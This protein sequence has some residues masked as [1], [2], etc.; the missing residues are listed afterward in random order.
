MWKYLSLAKHIRK[1]WRFPSDK[2]I[3]ELVILLSITQGSFLRNLSMRWLAL[4]RR[5]A[6]FK[7]IA[8]ACEHLLRNKIELFRQR[9]WLCHHSEV[10]PSIQQK[11]F[12]PWI[13][14]L[15]KH[16]WCWVRLVTIPHVTII[17]VYRSPKVP[18]S[19]MCLALMQILTLYPDYC[20]FILGFHMTSSKKKKK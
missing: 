1:L 11:P 10:V 17:Y 4:T 15:Q 20:I 18:V 6:E 8:Q 13:S 7:V 3:L 2:V 16:K 12:R 5:C 9:Y 14:S 19:Q